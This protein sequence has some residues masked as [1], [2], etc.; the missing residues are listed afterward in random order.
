MKETWGDT[1]KI[2]I[3]IGIAI[4]LLSLWAGST[5]DLFS[6]TYESP[7]IT[8]EKLRQAEVQIELLEQRIKEQ[9]EA[10]EN[11]TH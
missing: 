1:L 3:P 11:E 8:Q 10:Q 7:A 2:A 6:Q 9:Q 4:G 5:I